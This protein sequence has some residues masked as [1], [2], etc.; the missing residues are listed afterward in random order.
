MDSDEIKALI[1][2]SHMSF[3]AYEVTS[4]DETQVIYA[5][6]GQLGLDERKPYLLGTPYLDDIGTDLGVKDEER[7]IIPCLGDK[8]EVRLLQIPRDL[9]DA[10]D[11][12]AVQLTSGID[13]TIHAG[14]TSRKTIDQVL[15]R[16]VDSIDLARVKGGPETPHVDL[17]RADVLVYAQ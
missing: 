15:E 11:I 10:S 1:K 4:R 8:I 13:G 9:P 12:I 7:V 14:Y 6:I 16:N 3:G 2:G 17:A 5:S